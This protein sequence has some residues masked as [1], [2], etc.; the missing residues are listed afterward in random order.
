MKRLLAMLV[1]VGHGIAAGA[2]L[3]RAAA[4]P[5]TWPEWGSLA[6]IPALA[7]DVGAM[8]GM[9]GVLSLAVDVAPVGQIVAVRPVVGDGPVS[10]PGVPP[11]TE[12]LAVGPGV[13]GM[14]GIGAASA[15]IVAG[16]PVFIAVTSVRDTEML[17]PVMPGIG[18][19]APVTG[20]SV[21]QV[22]PLRAFAKQDVD[23]F[24]GLVDIWEDGP[25]GELKK[26]A[27]R[28][29]EAGDDAEYRRLAVAYWQGMTDAVGRRDANRERMES[30]KKRG[31]PARGR[32]IHKGDG[33]TP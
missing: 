8:G 9:A 31:M 23:P 20:N 32:G 6:S 26:A 16:L 12:T 29:A 13:P 10:G 25:L 19:L 15:L 5:V 14:G 30:A 3:A 27:K 2:A 7:V 22:K 33:Q 1:L 28:A 11:L 4:I 24:L 17:A 21:P 18:A